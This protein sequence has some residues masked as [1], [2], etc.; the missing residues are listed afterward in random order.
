MKNLKRKIMYHYN[1]A[2]ELA[3]Q[4]IERRARQLLA[5]HPKDLHEFLMGMGMAF[6]KDAEG[7]SVED[8][9]YLTAFD[10]FVNDMDDLFKITGTPMRFTATGEVRNNW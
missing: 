3:V 1:R 8:K 6:F 2:A 10:D 4:E 5:K 7:K 9:P